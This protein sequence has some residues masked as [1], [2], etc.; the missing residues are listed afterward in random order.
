MFHE[1]MF[2][3]MK[4]KHVFHEHMFMKHVFYCLIKKKKLLDVQS[5]TFS[6]KYLQDRFSF[7]DLFLKVLL[8]AG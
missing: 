3:F 1:H 6:A 5:S 4:H 7:K 2:V 8:F